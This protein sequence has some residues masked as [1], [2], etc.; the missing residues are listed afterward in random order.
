MKKNRLLPW[1]LAG[2]SLLV[3]CALPGHQQPKARPVTKAP[4]ALAVTLPNTVTIGYKVTDGRPLTD[5]GFGV[6]YIGPIPQ[7]GLMLTATSISIMQ[8]INGLTVPAVTI[9]WS[10]PNMMPVG[11]FG[12]VTN[13]VSLSATAA[14][15]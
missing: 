11:F 5:T 9:P 6:T 8:T 13:S 2:L 3:G 4:H 15:Q 10:N 1:L 14:S 12:I 7:V